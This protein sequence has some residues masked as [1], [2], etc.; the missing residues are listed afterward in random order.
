MVSADLRRFDD[1][2]SPEVDVIGLDW[3]AFRRADFVTLGPLDEKFAF[4]RGLDAW[5]SLVLRA[6]ADGAASRGAR[7]VALPLARH[8][9]R[10]WT[11]LRESERDRQA[12]RNYYRVLDQFR[13][14]PDL[15]AGSRAGSATTSGRE[16]Q[17]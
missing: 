8:A 2:I 13:G 6:G 15:L 12:K 16:P 7:R 10:G 11:S 4:H 1:D 14:R 5:W 17:G 3:M 9:H